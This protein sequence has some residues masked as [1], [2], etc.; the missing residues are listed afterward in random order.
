MSVRRFYWKET[1]LVVDEV[2][3]RLSRMKAIDLRK[4]NKMSTSSRTNL[5]K[6]LQLTS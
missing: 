6:S 2:A 1:H 5:N 3:P 4:L